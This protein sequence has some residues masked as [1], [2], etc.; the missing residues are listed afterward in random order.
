M[1]NPQISGLRT[2]NAANF[3]HIPNVTTTCRGQS[4]SCAQRTTKALKMHSNV[5][6]H[7]PKNEGLGW[8]LFNQF[9]A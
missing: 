7:V 6:L 2:E 4:N 3:M 9:G 8:K 5:F 1:V